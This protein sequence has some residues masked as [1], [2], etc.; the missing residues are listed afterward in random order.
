MLHSGGWNRISEY[1]RSFSVFQ[2]SHT[3]SY[4]GISVGLGYQT[5]RIPHRLPNRLNR[6]QNNNQ[7]GLG[8][9]QM[10][11]EKGRG[12]SSRMYLW[13]LIESWRHVSTN[14]QNSR[15]HTRCHS[16]LQ[17]NHTLRE[18]GCMRTR[19][20]IP[21]GYLTYWV[22]VAPTPLSASDRTSALSQS[23]PLGAKTGK[24]I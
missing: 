17:S 24:E 21:R 16:D 22:I 20:K 10:S 3:H 1:S 12:G 7:W 19:R 15:K 18:K 8:F 11:K 6:L 5:S 9:K 13:A 4:P 23:I 2:E 14:L